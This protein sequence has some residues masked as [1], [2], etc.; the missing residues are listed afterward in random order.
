LNVF[1]GWYENDF[2]RSQDGWKITVLRTPQWVEGNALIKDEP[3]PEVAEISRR[4]F[5]R[6]EAC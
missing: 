2:T 5:T 3:D 6:K 4:L 1:V